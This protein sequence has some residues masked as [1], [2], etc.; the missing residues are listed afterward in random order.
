MC[1][2]CLLVT[3][4]RN[5]GINYIDYWEYLHPASVS[6]EFMSPQF[7]FSVLFAESPGPGL[8]YEWASF[9]SVVIGQIIK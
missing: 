8:R 6:G 1:G 4:T 5:K 2:A 3:L 9:R 7:Y